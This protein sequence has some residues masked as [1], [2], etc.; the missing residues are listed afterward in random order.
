[1]EESFEIDGKYYLE[2]VAISET[3]SRGTLSPLPLIVSIKDTPGDGQLQ[4]DT[5]S[6]YIVYT[7]H[8]LVHTLRDQKSLTGNFFTPKVLFY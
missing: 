3:S 8:T 2:E 4:I 7:V 5:S 1:M 6:T